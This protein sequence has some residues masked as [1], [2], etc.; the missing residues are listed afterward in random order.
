MVAAPA[1]PEVVEPPPLPF[2]YAGAIWDEGR[3]AVI[4]VQGENIHIL[5]AGDRVDDLYRVERITHAQVEFTHLPL[6]RRQ[7]LG[8]SPYETQP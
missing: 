3:P 7:I 8:I 5:K 4:L 1:T 2:S 6:S